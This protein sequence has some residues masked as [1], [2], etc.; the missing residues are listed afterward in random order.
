MKYLFQ[1]GYLD[2]FIR[3]RERELVAEIEGY[4]ANYLLNV[5]LEDFCDYLIQKYLLQ[6]PLLR[7]EDTYIAE[8]GET[9]IDVSRDPL[10]MIPD[11]TQPFYV[12]GMSITFA[13]PF[14]G[15]SDLFKYKPSTYTTV[16]PEAIL[17]G[18]E[19]HLEF[20]IL[21]H[22]A[23]AVRKDYERSITEIA[24]YLGWIDKSVKQFN[25]RIPGLVRQRVS[26]RRGKLLRDQGMTSALGL[27]IKRRKDVAQTY[28]VPLHRQII[29]TKPPATTKSY[30]PEPVLEITEYDHI[31][32]I[33]SNMVQVMERSPTA[34]IKM[35]EEDLRQHFLVQLNGHYEGQATGETFNYEGKTDILVRV[36]GR[37][38]FIAE[39]KFWRGAES[40]KA[41]VDQLLGYL[42]WRDTKA[43][44]IL[45]NRNKFL[46]DILMKIPTLIEQH[47][48]F[49][50][51]LVCESETQFRFTLRQN[52][53]PNR[54]LLLT[55]LVF[56][57][58]V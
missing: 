13:L 19:L 12:R 27:P 23:A 39:C 7:K 35:E 29:P 48:N 54:D 56:D 17:A 32:K 21:D 49:K 15:N 46:S 31:L 9:N 20:K 45:F 16:L 43:A 37:N 10:R 57:V 1:S 50:R 5:N 28:S 47:E 25:N 51:K 40:F 55:V 3:D 22:D 30:T 4:E 38:I 26:Q 6:T 42:S 8:Q 53:D 24:E 36:E 33:I 34:F 41:T 44:I 11:R 58:P 18:N 52:S 14:E 2:E